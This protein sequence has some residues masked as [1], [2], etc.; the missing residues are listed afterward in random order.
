MGNIFFKSSRPS[1]STPPKSSIPSNSVKSSAKKAEE[2]IESHEDDLIQYINTFID[3][4][5]KLYDESI[6]ANQTYKRDINFDKWK[7]VLVM[8]ARTEGKPTPSDHV[9]E[10]YCIGVIRQSDKSYES[11]IEKLTETNEKI[12]KK[13]AQAIKELSDKLHNFTVRRL[14]VDVPQTGGKRPISNESIGKAV[15][16]IPHVFEKVEEI[17][18]LFDIYPEYKHLKQYEVPAE[19]I[20]NLINSWVPSHGPLGPGRGK[21]SDNVMFLF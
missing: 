17:K 5:L 9:I 21:L 11:I 12:R 1:P 15:A 6:N 14:F 19:F 7:D 16:K 20:E 8:D 2:E 13:L 18:E 10:M 4:V 3:N